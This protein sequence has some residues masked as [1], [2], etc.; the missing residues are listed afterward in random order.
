M[1][2]LFGYGAKVAATGFAL[3]SVF[4]WSCGVSPAGAASIQLASTA[5]QPADEVAFLTAWSRFYDAVNKAR[6]SIIEDQIRRTWEHAVCGVLPTGG[7]SNWVG[8]LASI[9]DDQGP[10]ANIV[11]QISPHIELQTNS[12]EEYSTGIDRHSALYDDLAK[13]E[14]G[15][16]VI[17]SG[18]FVQ[19]DSDR[20]LFLFKF[21]D[22]REASP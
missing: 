19:C 11:V 13:M 9:Y 3:W 16:R 10:G 2:P 14:E 20:S 8:T 6:N 18:K 17:F 12:Y 4:A 22:V 5:S 15:D 7:I 1:R 21:S